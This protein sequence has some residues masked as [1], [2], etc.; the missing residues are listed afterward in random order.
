MADWY[1]PLDWGGY[2]E[3]GLEKIGAPSWA[4]DALGYG[5]AP[6]T[7]GLSLLGTDLPGD[8][9]GGIG[10]F[11][12]PGT[13]TTT[14]EPWSAQQPYL[15]D[16]F[17][18]AQNLY[19]QGAPLTPEMSGLTQQYLHGLPGQVE[20]AQQYL[21]A[22]GGILSDIAGGGLSP[23]SGPAGQYLSDVTSGA[24]L[25]SNPYLDQMYQ[26]GAGDISRTFREATVPGIHSAFGG[27]AGAF[28]SG[29][30]QATLGQAQKE[31]G[32]ALGNLYT[33]IYNPAYQFERGLQQQGAGMLG[34]LGLGDIST[35]LSATGQ[36]PGLT[37]SY[38]DAYNLLR[39]GGQIPE[40]F[41]ASAAMDPW[42]RLQMY[43]QSVGGQYGGTTTAPGQSPFERWLGI[44][45]DVATVT[46]PFWM[47]SP[48]GMTGVS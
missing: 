22:G 11:F 44:G 6:F 26:Q 3:S 16:I 18:Q 19:G 14:Q 29:A 13:E 4:N 35:R 1:N 2:A 25:G 47:G 23:L 48:T 30:H 38:L 8:I 12:S 37:G 36:M 5:L 42:R 9:K 34:N 15:R 21:G 17:Q 27:S 32:G 28:G 39:Q 43:G 46:A 7:G 41:Q 33:G 31:L 24:Y 45:S 20:G 10:D 40:Q